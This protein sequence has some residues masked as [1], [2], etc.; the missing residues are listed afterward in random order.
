MLASID[1]QL[2][3]YRNLAILETPYGSGLRVSELIELK[4]LTSTLMKAWFNY[5]KKQTAIG[6]LGKISAQKLRVYIEEIRVHV[7]VKKG[8]Q[9]LFSSIRTDDNS[10]ER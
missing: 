6:A 1:L 3:G 7:P 10:P 8:H 9:T 2:L 5:G 4:I